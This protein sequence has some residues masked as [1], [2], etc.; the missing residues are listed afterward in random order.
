MTGLCL[1]LT[2]FLVEARIAT[3]RFTLAW[4]HSVEKIA[5]EEDYRLVDGRIEL[6]AARI[7][8]SG[9]GMEPPAGA[10]FRHNRWHYHPA[11]PPLAKLTLT[12]SPYTG[13]YRL[14]WDG[15]CRALTE[16]LGPPP[17]AGT[18]VNLFPCPL[19]RPG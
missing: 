2:L 6:V 12:R 19:R 17:A 3:D 1:G 13:G 9:A 16:L 7:E 8:G 15:A 4:N 10:V 11:V 14:C 5:W 18:T